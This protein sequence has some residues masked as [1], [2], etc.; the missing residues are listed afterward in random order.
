[1]RKL[2]FD[3]ADMCNLAFI[4][5]TILNFAKPAQNSKLWR[6]WMLNYENHPDRKIIF[7]QHFSTLT[8]NRPAKV[9]YSFFYIRQNRKLLILE[10]KN[11]AKEIFRC[12]IHLHK[13]SIQTRQTFQFDLTFKRSHAL[14]YYAIV[15]LRSQLSNMMNS[16]AFPRHTT[17]HHSWAWIE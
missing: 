8:Q 11:P 13:K 1:M 12:P 7:S 5:S 3:W 10:Q 15:F 17:S 2:S 9:R 14:I 4:A 6:Q 16:G